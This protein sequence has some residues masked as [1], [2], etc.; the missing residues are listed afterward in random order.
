MDLVATQEN[1]RVDGR[2]ARWDDHKRER[3]T[4]IID[5]A[6]EL[7][8]Q[9]A[10]GTEVHVQEI[11]DRAGIARPVLYRHFADRSDLDKAVQS[12][13]IEMILDEMDLA[14]ML[15]G[16][17]SDVI[18]RIVGTYVAWADAHPALHRVAVREGLGNLG[19]PLRNAVQAISEVIGPLIRAGAAQ[20]GATLDKDD[21]D[22]LDL[23][24]FG[25][26]SSAVGAVRLWLSRPERL[27]SAAAL[28]DRIADSVWF[29]LEGLA[30]VRGGEID[31]ARPIAEIIAAM[32]DVTAVDAS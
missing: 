10:P 21:E 7:I 17:I 4:A 8:E 30:R 6:I 26:V 14:A 11:A 32:I 16:T 23:L 22:A 3:R 19:S 5:A 20:Y 27:P 29:Q 13:A 1:E 25:L 2:R 31:P 15:E 18:H 12:R 9:H 28:T 24:I